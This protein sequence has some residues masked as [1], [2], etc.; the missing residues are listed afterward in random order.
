MKKYIEKILL[1]LWLSL[2]IIPLI[3]LAIW[4]HILDTAVW[5]WNYPED[6]LCRF[7]IHNYSWH[8]SKP[9]I[10]VCER[11]GKMKKRKMI[12]TIQTKER[13]NATS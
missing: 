11:C 3:L 9:S 1:L 2:A 5:Y 4:L 6:L 8:H 7:G 12:E 13:K 10:L